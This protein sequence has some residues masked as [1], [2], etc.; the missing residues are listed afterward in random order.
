MAHTHTACCVRVT[1][2]GCSNFIAMSVGSSPDQSTFALGTFEL[3]A[4]SVSFLVTPWIF[5]CYG[6]KAGL[7]AGIALGMVGTALSVLALLWSLPGL[8]LVATYCYGCAMGIGFYLR[9]AALELVPTHWSSFAVG[10]VVGGG[11]IAAIAAPEAAYGTTNMFGEDRQNVKYMGVILMTGIFNLLNA[12]FISFIKFPAST[13]STAP[14]GE[15]S[16]SKP[17]APTAKSP[18]WTALRPVLMSRTFLVPLAVAALS[19]AIM[20]LPMCVVRLAMLQ[21]GFAPRMGVYVIEGH[22]LGMYVTGFVSGKLIHRFGAKAMAAA[23]VPLFLV[24]IAVLQVADGSTLA[25]WLAGMVLH[26]VAWN[27]GFTSATVWTSQTAYD[28]EK[29]PHLKSPVQAA[30]DGAMFLF[31]GVWVMSSTY[32]FESVGGGLEGWRVVSGGVVSGLVLVMFAFLV[33]EAVRDQRDTRTRGISSD[34]PL[35]SPR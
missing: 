4:A 25:A 15:E 2:V 34:L 29:Q 7:L 16:S 14:P 3:G 8:F 35:H 5:R 23:S 19:W 10:L 21:V 22:F 30:N 18:A 28:A 32:L 17:S 1:V 31:V 33:Y 13:S 27:I 6:R 24:S 20:V 11:T 9:F 26:G 12:V